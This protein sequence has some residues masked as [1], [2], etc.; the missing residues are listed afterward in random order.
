M[1]GKVS[2]RGQK[3]LVQSQSDP[4]KIESSTVVFIFFRTDA[5]KIGVLKGTD[6]FGNR[7]YENKKYFLGKFILIVSVYGKKWPQV[8]QVSGQTGHKKVEPATHF[9]F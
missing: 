6:Q 9:F 2:V 8:K 1:V 4:H 5:L 7:Y 3:I